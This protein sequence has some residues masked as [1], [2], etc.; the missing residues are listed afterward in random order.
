[1]DPGILKSIEVSV[2]NTG[3]EVSED[4]ISD[5]EKNIGCPALV[6]HGT[7]LFAAFIFNIST[8]LLSDL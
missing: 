7:T 5:T 1:L 3:V 4:R 8:V 6:K 2:S